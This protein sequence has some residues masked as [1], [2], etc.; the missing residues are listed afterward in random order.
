VSCAIT[1]ALVRAEPVTA[2][3]NLFDSIPSIGRAEKARL[4]Q[5]EAARAAALRATS[6]A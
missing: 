5:T 1:I 2:A 3:L 6:V 4:R